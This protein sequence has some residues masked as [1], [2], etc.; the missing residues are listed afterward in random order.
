M[1]LLPPILA[2][3]QTLNGVV[4]DANTQSPLAGATIITPDGK[5][6]ATNKNGEFEISC[7]PTITISHIGY[8]TLN[9]SIN[10]CNKPITVS[11]IVS[12]NYLQMVEITSLSNNTRI[13]IEQP[14]SIAKLDK[15]DINRGTGLFLDDAMNA[16]VPK[17]RMCC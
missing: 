5:G 7:V 2:S 15:L 4:V 16:N 10:D 12:D 3:A 13:M 9:Q 1:L 6:V 11:L 8:N 14:M 17:I